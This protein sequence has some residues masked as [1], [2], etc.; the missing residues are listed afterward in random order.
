MLLFLCLKSR[1]AIVSTSAE[2]PD[3]AWVVKPTVAFL[4]QTRDQADK[5]ITNEANFAECALGSIQELG[6]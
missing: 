5:G 4:E 1:E 3:S 2:H 6:Q